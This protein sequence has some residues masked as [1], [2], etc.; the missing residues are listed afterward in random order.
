MYTLQ[1]NDNQLDLIKNACE[2]LGRHLIWQSSFKS[3]EL[4]DWAENKHKVWQTLLDMRKVIMHEY[5]KNETWA[6]IHQYP[7]YKMWQEPLMEIYQVSDS[8]WQ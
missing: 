6:N 8:Q 5:C 7:V 4:E 1:V 3:I 2:Y